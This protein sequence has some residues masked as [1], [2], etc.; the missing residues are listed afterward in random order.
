MKYAYY[1][2]KFWLLYLATGILCLLA[3]IG[4]DRTVTTIAEHSP[5]DRNHTIII[6]AGHGGED[7]GAISCTGMPESQINLQI[8]LRLRDLCHLIGYDTCM[9]RTSDVSVYTEGNSLAAKKASDLRQRVK[10]VNAVDNGILISIH[11]NIFADSRY[12][13]AQIF[14]APTEGSKALSD[15]LQS[16]FVECINKG[17]NRKCKPANGVYLMQHIER[18]GVL[19]ECG[20]LSNPAEEAKLRSKDYQLKLCCVIVSGLSR[21]INA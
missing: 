4:A 5:I 13:G 19:V 11:Q 17:S 12:D 15:Q 21:Y 3:T 10:I 6:D 8:A 2:K 1:L 18:P 20:F 16:T 7:G 14:Y 9:I